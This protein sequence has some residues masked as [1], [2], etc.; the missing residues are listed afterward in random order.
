MQ[1][2][3]RPLQ[4]RAKH[5]RSTGVKASVMA[6]RMSAGSW[7]RADW[8]CSWIRGAIGAGAGVLEKP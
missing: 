3:M 4:V 8:V 1:I 5:I 6:S 2:P 7:Q